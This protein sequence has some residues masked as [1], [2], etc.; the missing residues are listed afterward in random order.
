MAKFSSDSVLRRFRRKTDA[1]AMG[2]LVS[3]GQWLRGGEGGVKGRGRAVVLV[4]TLWII[5][6][7]GVVAS[8]LAFDVQVGSKL[9]MLQREQFLAQ[10][11]AKSAI[12]VGMTHLQNDLIIDYNE[13]PNQMVDAF[14]DVWAMRDVRE[15]ERVVQVDKDHPERT[16]ELS[17]EDEEGRIPLNHAN[18]K[19]MKAMMEYYGFEEPDSD[20]VGHAIIDYRDQDDMSGMEPGTYENEYFSGLMGQRIRGEMAADQLIYR[21]P[22]ER[23]FTVDQLLDVYGINQFPELFLGYDPEEHEEQQLRIRDSVAQGRTTRQSRQRNRRR[24]REPLPIKDIVTVHPEGNG[25]ININTASVDVMTILIHAATDFTSI[26]QAKAAA[27]A[28]ADFRGDTSNRAPDPDTAFKSIADVQQVPGVD[29]EALN[30]LQSLGVQLAFRSETFRIT[31]IGRTRNAERSVEAVIQ[32]K[33]E[34][35]NPD[36]ARLASNRERGVDSRRRRTRDRRSGGNS[37]RPDDNYIRVPAI[38]VLQWIE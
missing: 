26:E 6:V 36:D 1:L 13:N 12:A 9:A 31:G 10:N 37:E 20:E 35:Y 8:S 17:I 14:S 25:R 7:L 22:N 16:Y 11:L 30:N 23:Y 19:V 33:L 3:T 24:N 34:V 21:T 5:V 29:V 4:V 2:C 28:I 15:S 32:R 27:E 38:R 18:F